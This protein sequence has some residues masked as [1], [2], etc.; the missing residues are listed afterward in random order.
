MMSTTRVFRNLPLRAAGFPALAGDAQN[1]RV[2][3]LAEPV[4]PGVTLESVSGALF[5]QDNK[6]AGQ[7]SASAEELKRPTVMGALLAPPGAYRLRVAAIDST[8]R[9]GTADYDLTAEIVRSG[10][11]KLSSLVLG[12]SRGGGFVP[13]LQ[14]ID[15]P[16]AIAYV[17]M[18]GVAAGAR[19]N[20]ALEVAQTLN[21]AA[22]VTVPLTIETT[23]ENRYRAMGSVPMGALPAGDYVARAVIGVDGSPM[24]RVV[25]TFRKAVMAPARQP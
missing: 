22:V 15:E 10:P 4:E 3:V 6:L 25:R 16:L 14:F 7:W 18:E 8:G 20:V 11:L 9:A 23:G 1:I 5:N 13:K 19:V 24:T 21:G 2:I 17:E 12:L